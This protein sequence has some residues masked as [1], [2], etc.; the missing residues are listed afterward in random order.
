M[1]NQPKAAATGGERRRGEEDELALQAVPWSPSLLEAPPL[2]G[3]V[4]LQEGK[5]VVEPGHFGRH[6]GEAPRPVGGFHGRTK[7]ARKGKIQ[8]N[9]FWRRLRLKLGKQEV[10]AYER[11]DPETYPLARAFYAKLAELSDKEVLKTCT[12]DATDAGVASSDD[13][14]EENDEDESTAITATDTGVVLAV[15]T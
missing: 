6:R 3:K 7:L 12:M 9:S 14:D 10:R 1:A 2:W 13:H 8:H 11:F 4:H 5:Q 15:T